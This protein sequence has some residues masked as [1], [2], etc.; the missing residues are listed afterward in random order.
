MPAKNNGLRIHRLSISTYFHV[1]DH[2]LAVWARPASE[3]TF[4]LRCGGWPLWLYCTSPPRYTFACEIPAV[5]YIAL[6]IQGLSKRIWL[7]PRNFALLDFIDEW[8]LIVA[9]LEGLWTLLILFICG[10]IA[11]PLLWNYCLVGGILDGLLG[12]CFWH[13]ISIRK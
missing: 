4:W 9:T 6:Q 11:C 13:F 8:R 1:F 2:S 7:L 3:E 12:N 10:R 5:T